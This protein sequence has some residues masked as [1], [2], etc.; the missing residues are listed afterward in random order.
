ML[1]FAI[2]T[3]LAT[4]NSPAR[5]VAV[6]CQRLALFVSGC[7]HYVL[8]LSQCEQ[9]HRRICYGLFPEEG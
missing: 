3:M 2:L 7:P 4:L 5:P 9:A 8:G 1:S 6:H